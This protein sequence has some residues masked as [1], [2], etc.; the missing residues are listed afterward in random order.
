MRTTRLIRVAAW[1]LLLGISQAFGAPTPDQAGIATAHPLATQAGNEILEAG[2]NAFDAAVAISA[3]L[4]VVEPYASGLGGGAFWLL[5]V[6]EQQTDTFVDARE[7]APSAATADMYLDA[8]G[9]PIGRAS[10][11]GPLASGIP[12]QAAGLVH[13]AERYGRLPLA[14]SL[15]PAIRYA[16]EGVPVHQ[17]MLL[18]LRFRRSAADRWPAFGEVY[19]PNGETVKEGDVLRQ[20]DLAGTLRRLAAKGFDGFYRGKT[21]R[22]LLRGVQDGGGIWVAD[23]LADYRVIERDPIAFFYHGVRIISAP[24]PSSGGIAMA[25]MLNILNG[26]DLSKLDGAARK[27]LTIEAMRRAYRDRAEFLGDTDF[28]EVPVRRLMSSDYAAGQRMS[29]RVDRATPSDTLAGFRAPVSKGADTTHFSVLDK[30]GNRVAG[31]MSINTWYGSAFMA[32]GTGLIM[33]NEMDDFAIKP[34]LPNYYGL[35]GYSV[36]AIEPGKRMLSSMSPTFLESGRG[37]AI[38]GTPGGSRII[39]MVLLAAMAW[40]D[41]ADAQE[42]VELKRYHHQFTPDQVEHEDGAFSAEEVAALE[43]RGHTLKQVRRVYGNM[44]VVTWD[45]KSGKVEAVSDPRG[46][47]EGRVY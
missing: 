44:N 33:N 34:G 26:Y 25:N 46:L 9:Q 13:L 32:P 27:H 40:M 4:G 14:K 23:D 41:G 18:G 38:L 5:H 42:M 11:N 43:A 8:D 19:Y 31:T 2:G 6:A 15:A 30:D 28:T 1:C 47:G 24:P 16:E 29:I 10:F 45:F 37:V 7:V 20:P 21:A 39:T 12:G 36:N 17:R 3:A 22:L 35:P